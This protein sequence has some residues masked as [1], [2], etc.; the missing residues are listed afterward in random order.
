LV[1]GDNDQV[2]KSECSHC[3]HQ[4]QLR[5]ENEIDLIRREL[6]DR[7]ASMFESLKEALNSIGEELDIKVN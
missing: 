1:V 6:R 3:D 4:V 7:E 2:R 5:I